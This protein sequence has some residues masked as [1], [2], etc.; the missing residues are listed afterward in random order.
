MELSKGGGLW[1]K[2]SMLMLRFYG[3]EYDVKFDFIDIKHLSN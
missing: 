1:N 2:I 3:M